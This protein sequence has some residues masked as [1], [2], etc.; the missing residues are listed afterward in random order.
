MS[1]SKLYIVAEIQ[2]GIVISDWD[3]GDYY[4][5]VKTY[6]NSVKKVLNL[7]FH[8]ETFEEFKTRVNL[9]IGN[10][11]DMRVEF[12]EYEMTYPYDWEKID[13][14]LDRIK[15]IFLKDEKIKPE[16]LEEF[17]E[18]YRRNETFWNRHNG[19][20]RC[21]EK[22]DYEDVRGYVLI[23]MLEEFYF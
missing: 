12:F 16:K 13:G 20:V 6:K 18:K 17:I 3:I 23:K 9:K 2:D 8:D 10:S 21:R 5:A 22:E 7:D 14:I 15:N 4:K 1:N 11:Q 19:D